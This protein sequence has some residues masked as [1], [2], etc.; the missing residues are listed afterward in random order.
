VQR[1]PSAEMQLRCLPGLKSSVALELQHSKEFP[2]LL[3]EQVLLQGLW[4]LEED[5]KKE[6]G[7]TWVPSSAQWAARQ[8]RE[9][10]F[11]PRQSAKCR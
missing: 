1:F 8:P 7:S 11:L 10:S 3:T 6:S 2:F 4:A 9:H 5:K